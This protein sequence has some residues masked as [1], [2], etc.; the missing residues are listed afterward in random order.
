MV[1][2]VNTEC[3]KC[4]FAFAVIGWNVTTPWYCPSCTREVATDLRE[5]ATGQFIALSQLVE[6]LRLRIDAQTD[7]SRKQD[8][9]A[10]AWETVCEFMSNKEGER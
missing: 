10:T 2:F 1:D 6:A 8:M 5:V 7:T 3:G 4:G 9:V